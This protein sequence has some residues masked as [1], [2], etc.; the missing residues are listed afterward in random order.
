MLTV[1]NVCLFLAG[2]HILFREDSIYNSFELSMLAHVWKSAFS[3]NTW[4]KHFGAKHICISQTAGKNEGKSKNWVFSGRYGYLLTGYKRRHCLFLLCIS[5]RG[6]NCYSKALR[7]SNC[8]RGWN[9]MEQRDDVVTWGYPIWRLRIATVRWRQK[10]C[11][12][13]TESNVK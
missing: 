7:I 10:K 5:L 13:V 6:W 9:N 12:H 11:E 2:V 4:I 8:I 1:V 3:R